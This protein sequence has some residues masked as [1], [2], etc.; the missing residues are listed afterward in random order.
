[1]IDKLVEFILSIIRIFYICLLVHP[2]QAGIILRLG[3]FHRVIGPGLRFHFPFHVEESLVESVVRETMVIKPQ[4]LTTKDNKAVVVSSVVT[5]EISDIKDFLL[6]IEGRNAFLQDSTYGSTSEFVMKHT[7]AE[8][9]A[10]QDI[11]VELAKVVRR[12]A[13]KY[14][15]NIISVQLVDFIQCKS[16]R[17]IQSQI[18]VH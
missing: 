9:M 12:N 3:K 17:L 4:S 1:M 13:K 18:G 14:G 8:L 15:V 6:C 11:G 16:L 5:F 2:Y 10:L 7:W